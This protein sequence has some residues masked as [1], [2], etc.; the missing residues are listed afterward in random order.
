MTEVLDTSQQGNQNNGGQIVGGQT[1]T[2]QD[3]AKPPA[4]ADKGDGQNFLL[5]YATMEDAVSGVKAGQAKITEL[6][7]KVKSLESTAMDDR[8][9][10]L[11]NLQLQTRQD[12]DNSN[13]AAAQ[14]Q[15]E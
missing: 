9:M 2:G 15:R 13:R 8:V 5:D 14:Q 11:E 6:A 4:I 3:A 7:N 10:Q 12:R 1:P